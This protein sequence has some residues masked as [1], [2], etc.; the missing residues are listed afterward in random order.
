MYTNELERDKKVII[1]WLRRLGVEFHTSFL[2]I[3]SEI[4]NHP[5]V[6]ANDAFYKMIGYSEAETLGRNGRFLHGEKTAKEASDKVRACVASGE[7]GVVEIVNYRKNGTPFWN[8]IS[9]EPLSFPE[10]NFNFTLMLQHDI[11]DRKRAEALIKLQKETYRGI[12][13]GHML[14]VLL[15]DICQTAESF[16]IDSAKCTVL[17]IDDDEFYKIGAANSMPKGFQEAISGLAV[18]EDIGTCGAAF[19]RQKLV[20]VEDMGSD[21]LWR[22]H[23]QLVK[24]YGLVASWSIPIFNVE[25]KTMGTFGIYFSVP[26]T[27]HEEDLA[28]MEE[29]GSITSLAIKYSQQQEKILRLAYVDEHTGLPNRNYFRNEVA[30]L[31]KEKREGFIAFISTD[32]YVAVVD[33]YG[34]STGDTIMSEI[35]KRLMLSQNSSEGLIARF[36]DSTLAMFSMMPFTKIP[37]YLEHLLQ[38]LVEPITVGDMELFLTL[39]IG[40]AVVTPH[41]ENSEELIRCA[42]SALSQAKLR[43]GEAICYF[44]SEHDEF[45]MKYLRVANELTAALRRNEVGVHLQ[46]K[47]DLATGEILSFEALA[48]W[49]SPDLGTISPD[50]FIPAAEKNGKIR[51]LEQNILQQVLDWMKKRVEQGLKIRQVAI[52]ISA[53]HFFHHSFVPHLMDMTAEYGIDPQWIQLEI[54]ER[55]GFVD[56]ETANK[57]FKHLKQCGFTTSIDDF[58]TGYSSLSYLQKLPVEELKI[59][60]SFISNMNEPGTLA[61][62]RTIIQLAENLNMRAVAEGVETEKDRQTLLELGCKVGQGYLFY[63]PMPLNEAFFL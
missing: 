6:Y 9:V 55:I 12:E 25:G 26:L 44:E 56:I 37:E 46:P 8:E 10:K 60:R 43:T 53:D 61:I 52:N 7:S 63:K 28:F 51:L 4:E 34:H 15:Q 32:E 45:M 50:V 31:L 23:Q 30:E 59:D 54:T 40:V 62:I 57:V 47:V 42:D 5:I 36:S 3:N 24:E 19:H 14:S 2:I 27:P 1:E 17:L 13:K 39:K 29:I 33:Q 35:G 49:T 58:G 16:F 41:Q 18:E 21:Y 22:N 20:V 48:R 11:T 38:G